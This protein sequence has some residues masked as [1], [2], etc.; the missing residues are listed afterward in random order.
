MF[1]FDNFST[2][3]SSVL[4][5]RESSRDFSIAMSFI[6]AFDFSSS[7]IAFAALSAFFSA[8]IFASSASRR[9]SF[10][11]LSSFRISSTALLKFWS[12]D[13]F[14]VLA[15]VT[16]FISSSLTLN[17]SDSSRISTWSFCFSF[18]SFSFSAENSFRFSSKFLFNDFISSLL[19]IKSCF[20]ASN[21]S[22]TLSTV[23][24]DSSHRFSTASFSFL[25]LWIISSLSLIFLLAISTLRERSSWKTLRFE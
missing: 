5:V 18:P 4:L 19:D 8:N 15:C 11:S 24:C 21:S 6:T 3:F 2:L 25:A 14:A 17:F 7:S 9:L 13:P 23:R 16:E 12:S 1:S 20:E 22:C 10:V